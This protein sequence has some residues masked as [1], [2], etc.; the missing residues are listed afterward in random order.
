MH[1]VL[2]RLQGE[3]APGCQAR[4]MALK[5][6]WDWRRCQVHLGMG[7]GL[8]A[9]PSGWQVAHCCWDW[10]AAVLFGAALALPPLG[11][12]GMLRCAHCSIQAVEAQHNLNVVWCC[13]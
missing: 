5:C 1:P 2:C 3:A 8:T 11:C 12:L 4:A 9:A 7:L 6:C 10:P 13:A